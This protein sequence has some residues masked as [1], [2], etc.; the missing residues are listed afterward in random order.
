MTGRADQRGEEAEVKGGRA[1]KGIREWDLPAIFSAFVA[2]RHRNSHAQTH[3]KK[4]K[5]TRKNT[6]TLVTA[7]TLSQREQRVFCGFL[8]NEGGIL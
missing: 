2:P 7:N 4:K 3:A 1:D 6:D 5:K 8:F